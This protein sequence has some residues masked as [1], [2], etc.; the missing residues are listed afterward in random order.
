MKRRDFIKK[1]GLASASLFSAPYI[2]PSGRLFAATGL[3][4]VNHVVFCL[5]AGGIR[6]YES[7]Q[8]NDGN[9]MPSLLN[10]NE[11]ISSDILGSMSSLP[12]SALSTPLQ[13]L[14]T[15]F[16]EFRYDQGPTGHFNG[17]TT[18]VTGQYTDSSLNLNSRPSFPTIFELYRKH[19]SPQMSALNSWWITHTN[20]LY[21]NLNYSLYPDYGPDFGA[22][23]IAPTSFFTAETFPILSDKNNFPMEN[24]AFRSDFKTFLNNNFGAPLSESAGVRNNEE[25]ATKLEAW[26]DQMTTE[27][28]S[29]LHNNPFNIPSGMNNDMHNI[30]YAEKVI[31]EFKPELLLVNMFGVDVCHNDFT[32]YCDNLRK[33]DWAVGHLWSKIQ[34]TPGM[35]D[36]TLLIVAPEIGRN[37]TPNSI[38]DQNGR[39]ALDHTNSDPVAKEIFCLVAGPSGV[40]N[41]GKVL[42]NE[43]GKSVD[44]VPTIANALG[45]DMDIPVSLPGKVLN[46]AFL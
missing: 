2:L 12:A 14:G 42:S 38:S 7:V 27:I 22:N 28:A 35:A 15:L 17:H 5:F 43:E 13:N 16:K 29:G 26:F 23:Q 21:P 3:R 8:K 37:G 10:G 19:N 45:F 9:L 32:A 11:S 33:A 36:D 20:N 1:T 6:N 46:E 18:A 24:E 31:E 44:I 4:K 41:Q 40:V 30:F 25:D 34:S 39:Y